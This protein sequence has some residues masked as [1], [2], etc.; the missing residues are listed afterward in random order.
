MASMTLTSRLAR[1]EAALGGDDD[2][3]PLMLVVERPD[4]TWWA[5]GM[6]VDKTMTAPRVVLCRGEPAPPR[7]RSA[8]PPPPHDDK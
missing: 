6:E 1:L 5:N 8:D 3:A 4:G 7:V 2:A